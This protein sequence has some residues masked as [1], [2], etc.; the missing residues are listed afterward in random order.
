MDPSCAPAEAKLFHNHSDAFASVRA[1]L[2]LTRQSAEV[3]YRFT[4]HARPRAVSPSSNHA[5]RRVHPPRGFVDVYLPAKALIT[6]SG[7]RLLRRR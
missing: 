1:D 5:A 3:P 6:A 2:R 7:E 4:A